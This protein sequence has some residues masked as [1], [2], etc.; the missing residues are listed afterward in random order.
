MPWDLPR[1]ADD[2]DL[3]R[4]VWDPVYRRAV[5]PLIE[6]EDAAEKTTTQDTKSGS[7]RAVSKN[8]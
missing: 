1:S 6:A 4:L 7:C 3:N 2:I 8:H 5:R